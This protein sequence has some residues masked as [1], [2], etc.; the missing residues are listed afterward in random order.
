MSTSGKYGPLH[1]YRVGA[2][3]VP[4]VLGPMCTGDKVVSCSFLVFYCDNKESR[5]V[6]RC[7]EY[8]SM[9]SKQHD[10]LLIF[11]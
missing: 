7:T 3:K 2:I 6:I 11:L 5:N 8:N 9:L 4:Y 1:S 10:I